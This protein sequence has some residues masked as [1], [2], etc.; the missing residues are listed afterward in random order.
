MTPNQK[1]KELLDKMSSQTYKIQP[2]AGAHYITEEVGWE[3][4]KKCALIAVEEI[5]NELKEC[6]EVWMKSRIKYWQEVKE[7]LLK[8][9]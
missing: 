4:G 5:I 3:A 8:N 7:E 9:Y 6:G 1:A 2:Y